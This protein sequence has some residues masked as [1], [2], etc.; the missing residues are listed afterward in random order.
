MKKLFLDTLAGKDV[1]ETPIWI[2]RQ[3]G[4]YLPEYRRIRSNFSDFME[5]CHNAEACCEVA[6]QPLI[7]Y[8]LDASIV[9]SDI[10]TVPQAMGMK[11]KFVRDQGPIFSAPLS[12][13]SDIKNLDDKYA[14]ENLQYVMKAI[15]LTKKEVKVPLIGFS[16]SPWTL[17]AYMIEGKGSKNFTALRKMLYSAPSQLHILL[18]KLSYVIANYLDQQ[19]KSGV[20]ALMIFDTWGGGAF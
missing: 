6:L 19:I 8:N 20:D 2:M 3:A 18:S 5:M 11:L 16:G 17:A 13:L 1:S 10:L 4:R 14:I 12:N 7:R 15:T 9:F